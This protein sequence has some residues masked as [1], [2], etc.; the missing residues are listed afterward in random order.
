[1]L[2]ENWEKPGEGRKNQL[3]ENKEV[4]L[5]QALSGAVIQKDVKNEA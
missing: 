3:F 1:V 2:G 4:R 5:M